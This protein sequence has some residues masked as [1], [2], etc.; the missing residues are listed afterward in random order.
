MNMFKGLMG[1]MGSMGGPPGGAPGGA[2]GAGPGG[3][4]A[5]NDMFKNFTQFL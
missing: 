2:P 4:N 5:M 3:D 1:N